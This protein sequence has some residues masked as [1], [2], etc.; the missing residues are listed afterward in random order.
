MSEVAATPEADES[1]ERS[2]T[3]TPPTRRGSRDERREATLRALAAGQDAA[4]AYCGEPL[5][6]LP[7]RGGRPTPYCAPDPDRY[8]QW[9][10]KTI[11][12]AMLDEQREIWT[13][14]YGPDQP[15]TH[16]DVH[17]LDDR[18]TALTG[19]LDPVR[20]EI[21]ALQQHATEQLA[22]ALTA[23]STAE[24]DRDDAL[25]K[26][27][28]AEHDRDRARTETAEAR[29]QVATAR[30]AQ[31]AAEAERDEAVQERDAACADR[32]AARRDSTRAQADR[33]TALAQA[34]AAQQHITELNDARATE[35]ATALD[36]QE[37]LRRE[38]DEDRQRLRDELDRHWRQ[39]LAEQE[40]ELTRQLTAT[41]EAADTRAAELTDRLTEA[42]RTYAAGLA[43]LHQEL[44]AERAA[45]AEQH[46]AAATAR[47]EHEEFRA[48]LR[49]S[50]TTEPAGE[51]PARVRA[52]LG[53]D[54]DSAETTG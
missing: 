49:Q 46:A 42:T 8:G 32:D 30:A 18:L 12:C 1:A 3:R 33:H 50:L 53:Q 43:P 20:T 13:R 38:A 39:Q 25:E 19:V 7:P 36:E 51:L 15:M 47:R 5:P 37:R 4:C 48:A 16:L 14:V 28:A 41:R 29:E 17:A 45:H 9:G 22:T 40:A 52:L 11:S 54:A 6:P 27:R 23:R 34:A 2:D 44:A 31:E 35:R 10:A 21:A 24:A 26:S